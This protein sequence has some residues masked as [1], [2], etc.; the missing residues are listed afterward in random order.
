[1]FPTWARFLANPGKYNRRRNSIYISFGDLFFTRS[2]L[3]VE[4]EELPVV[5]ADVVDCNASRDYDSAIP[6]IDEVN[7]PDVQLT[8][9]KYFEVGPPLFPSAISTLGE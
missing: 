3:P 8:P 1:M 2:D 6:F 5:I 7:Q 4:E 9:D